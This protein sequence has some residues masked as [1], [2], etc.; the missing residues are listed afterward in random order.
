MSHTDLLMENDTEGIGNLLYGELTDIPAMISFA[1]DAEGGIGLWVLVLL[2]VEKHIL[3]TGGRQTCIPEQVG[4][5]PLNTGSGSGNATALGDTSGNDLQANRGFGIENG[6]DPV[7]DF[8]VI[9]RL[10]KAF[11]KNTVRKQGCNRIDRRILLLLR[12]YFRKAFLGLTSLQGLFLRGR[13][14]TSA[15]AF[16]L[17]CCRR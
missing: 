7:A 15:Q 13:G 5:M 11:R 10:R 6:L 4:N 12:D 14:G 9:G 1:I 17:P 3:L 16:R 8:S 2:P